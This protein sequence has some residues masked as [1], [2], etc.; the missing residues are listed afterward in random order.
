MREAAA[1]ATGSQGTAA[2][3]RRAASAEQHSADVEECE[4][5]AAWLHAGDWLSPS[6]SPAHPSAAAAAAGSQGARQQC[7]QE[8]AQ[9][10]QEQQQ[11]QQ[12]VCVEQRL[13]QQD[14]PWHQRQLS[15]VLAA[16][17][18]GLPDRAASIRTSSRAQRRYAARLQ[19]L[20]E[21]LACCRC[22]AKV[23]HSSSWVT[24]TQWLT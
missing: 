17:D 13:L 14:E 5:D 21:V 24:L 1:A 10:E 6:D 2:A 19:Q 7:Q 16:A 11:E 3:A 8:Q 20:A 12:E 15:P 4:L 9:Q 23:F 18:D 22:D